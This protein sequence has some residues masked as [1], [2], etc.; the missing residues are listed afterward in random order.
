MPGRP[1]LGST[2]SHLGPL[3]GTSSHHLPATLD[4][5]A[6]LYRLSPTGSRRGVSFGHSF[7]EGTIRVASQSITCAASS[8]FR[9][10]STHCECHHA[11]QA[12][13]VNLVWGDKWSHLWPSWGTCVRNLWAI[14][15]PGP[16][17]MLVPLQPSRP[18]R[19]FCGPTVEC[20][21]KWNS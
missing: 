9:L 16:S 7:E 21:S 18:N 11:D 17:S 5:G 13:R 14:P 15:D 19:C 8:L 12:C 3:W 20:A 2:W 1:R 4:P 6:C 10:P